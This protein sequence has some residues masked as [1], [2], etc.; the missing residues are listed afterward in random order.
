MRRKPLLD[1]PSAEK[2]VM[3]VARY[4]RSELMPALADAQAFRVRI[5]ANALDLA[6]REMAGRDRVEAAEKSRLMALLGHG[7]DLQT[8]NRELCAAIRDGFITA[9]TPGLAEH[10]WASALDK[11]SIEQPAYG[12]YRQI[13]KER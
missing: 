3:A 12:T 11:I 2:L 6:A 5:A 7:G 1:E 9:D 4:L 10:L 13:L 8:L